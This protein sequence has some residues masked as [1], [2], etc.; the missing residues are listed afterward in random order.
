[1][2][3]MFAALVLV[4]L[5]AAVAAHDFIAPMPPGVSGEATLDL[6]R[7]LASPQFEGR[8]IGTR[9]LDSAAVWIARKMKQAR[10]R[11]GGDDGTYFQS[12]EITT[13]I[14]VSQPCAIELETVTHDRGEHFQPIGFSTNGRLVAPVVFAGYGISA[15][16]FE[17]DDYAGIDARDKIVLILSQEPGEM[18]STSRFDGDINT[19]YAQL[20]TKAIN[21]REH[22]ALGMLVVDGPR[23]HEGA[24]VR[25][26]QLRGTGYMTSGLVAGRISQD[27]ADALLQRAGTSLADAQNTIDDA[28]KPNSFAVP[29]SLAVSV[30]LRRTRAE[31]QNVVGW[32][33]GKDT[34]RTIVIGA[35]YDHLGYGNDGSLSPD[36]REPHVG[37]DDNASG[38]AVMLKLAEWAGRR[39]MP[40]FDLHENTH[41]L[42]FCAFTAEESGLLGSSHYVNVPTFPLETVEAM[43]NMDMVGRMRDSSLVVMGAGTAVEFDSLLE[44]IEA[45]QPVRL[46]TTEDGYGPSD[47]SSF[48]KRNVP[49]LALFTG[50]HRDYHRP[51]DT[52]DK[53]NVDGLVRVESFARDVLASFDDMSTI[54]Y[55]KAAA[56]QTVGRIRGGGGYGAYLGTIPD[57]VQTEGGVLLSGVR[58]GGPADE[59]GIRGGDTVIKFDG[60]QID[61]IYDYTYALR[62]RKPGQ[63]VRITVIR[64]GAE[65]DLD[66]TLG[67]RGSTGSP[68]GGSTGS[69]HGSTG[70]PPGGTNPHGTQTNS[71]GHP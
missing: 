3:R 43:I 28:G 68:R 61:N 50:A 60:V 8:G 39:W 19:P 58:E 66:V 14:E 34:T 63:Q 45:R 25:S 42:V 1:M 20:R 24:D 18:D 11:P 37:A 5:P 16:G 27:V 40:T 65:I 41:N 32:I 23:Y 48:Y 7:E 62:S 21:A 59:G 6:V 9:G 30:T 10:L 33:P 22:G 38:T 4:A 31:V 70:S 52:W 15:P 13:G 64:D 67:K 54:T 46:R 56:D 53:I 2:R 71:G 26:P 36:S 55:R 17:Y 44:E 49:V 29:G 47:H 35:H 69:P 51:S 57:Y 12:F